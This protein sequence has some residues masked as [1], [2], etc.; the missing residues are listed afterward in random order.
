VDRVGPVE[1]GGRD[2]GKHTLYFECLEALQAGHC[3]VCHLAKQ[4]V[5]RQLDSLIYESVN[6]PGVRAR[7]AAAQGFCRAHAW[8]LRRQGGALGIAIVYRDVVRDVVEALGTAEYGSGRLSLHSLI[9]AIDR[10]RP[11]R[12]TGAAV[13]HLSPTAG[14]PA[15]LGQQRAERMYAD[16]VLE[17]VAEPEM[18]A[19]LTEN[20]GLCLPHLRLA[21]ERVRDERRFR[22]LVLASRNAFARLLDDLDEMIRRHDY[23]FTGGLAEFGDAWIRAITRVTGE[24]GLSER[25]NADRR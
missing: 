8:Q 7:T 23:R 14:C 15:C 10:E 12:A 4:T 25:R 22:L 5:A 19:A 11:S 1:D 21:L 24:E 18:H 17:S 13:R 16:V 6:D 2:S 20:P 9:E 3:P